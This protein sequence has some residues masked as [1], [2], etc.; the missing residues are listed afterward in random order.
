M[1]EVATV[2]LGLA[3]VVADDNDS[4]KFDVFSSLRG[5]AEGEDFFRLVLKKRVVLIQMKR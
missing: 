1:S 4:D 5:D 2:E 3:P